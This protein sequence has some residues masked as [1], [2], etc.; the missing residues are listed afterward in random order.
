M[1]MYLGLQ[2]T[3][4]EEV[5]VICILQYPDYNP[6]VSETL[7]WSDTMRV[8][9]KERILQDSKAY[10]VSSIDFWSQLGRATC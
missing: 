8:R 9:K 4:Q 1:L 5:I 7:G 10:V 6:G 3:V 2:D